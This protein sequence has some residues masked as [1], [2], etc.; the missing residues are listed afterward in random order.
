MDDRYLSALLVF[1]GTF[2][3]VMG[4]VVFSG[5]GNRIFARIGLT[6]R[7]RGLI[8]FIVGITVLTVGI[9]MQP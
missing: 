3:F 5:G 1:L 2:L 7:R 6:T 4:V 8:A 9:S